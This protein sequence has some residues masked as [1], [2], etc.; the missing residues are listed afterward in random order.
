MKT[1]WI[2]VIAVW[3]LF[4]LAVNLSG[5]YPWLQFPWLGLVFILFNVLYVINVVRHRSDGRNITLAHQ[6]WYPLWFRRFVYDDDD[7][8]KK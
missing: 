4:I 7:P 2:I 5:H 8:A 6:S 1:K 3:T